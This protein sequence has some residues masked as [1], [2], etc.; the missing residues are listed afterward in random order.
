[1]YFQ[2]ASNNSICLQQKYQGSPVPAVG[3]L[4]RAALQPFPGPTP[5]G[6]L[7]TYHIVC[8]SLVK[9]NLFINSSQRLCI[10]YTVTYLQWPTSP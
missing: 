10:V 7:C 8:N 9:R 3:A 4:H 5:F 6:S 1:M 2:T